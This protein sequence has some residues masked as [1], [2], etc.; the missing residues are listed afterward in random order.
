[1]GKFL[2]F[3]DMIAALEGFW[4]EK[5]CYIAQP[6]DIEK[7]A[8][9]MNPLTF[10][11]ALGPEPWKA[12]YVEP[13][14]RPQDARYG[15]N[16]YRMGYYFQF[17]VILKPPPEMVVE[18]YIESLERLGIR[19]EEH[20]IRLVEDN[21]ESPTLGASG[22]GWEVW[23]DGNEIAQ[24]TYFQE[25]GGFQVNP[26]SCEITYG[27]ERLA[28]YIQGLDNS[29]DVQLSP[30]LKYRDVFLEQEKQ[31]SAYGFEHA[32]PDLWRNVFDMYEKESKKILGQGLVLPSYDCAL[33]CSHAFNILDARGALS[34]SERQNYIGRVRA[35]TR[36]CARKYLESRG[37]NNNGR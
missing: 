15:D 23:L 7:G 33:K 22:L 9:T 8:G 16:P 25:M 18:M 21:W 2:S 35:L 10:F 30:G 1:M 36:E 20:D 14:R 12:A 11:R 28:A 3:C 29:W 4:A 32:D 6:Y 27:L 37:F 5:G 13:S 34:V 17:Q 24:F 26:I 31:G 19:R